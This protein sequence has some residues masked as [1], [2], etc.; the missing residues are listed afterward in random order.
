MTTPTTEN[1]RRTWLDA[2]PEEFRGQGGAAFNRWLAT[3]TAAGDYHEGWEE[4]YKAGLA[5]ATDH[6]AEAPSDEEALDLEVQQLA[7]VIGN[8]IIDYED[9]GPH[10]ERPITI[11]DTCSDW[12]MEIAGE[13]Q[14]HGFRLA[15]RPVVDDALSARITATLGSDDWLIVHDGHHLLTADDLDGRAA[16]EPE[17]GER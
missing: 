16:L 6:Q 14:A 11:R 8:V 5:A 17:K 4:G 9:T 12:P 13:V 15:A 10:S 2:Y 1:I 7:T 3:Q